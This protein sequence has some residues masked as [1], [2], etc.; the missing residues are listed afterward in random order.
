MKKIAL[1]ARNPKNWVSSKDMTWDSYLKHYDNLGNLVWTYGIFK[2]LH[3]PGN[4]LTLIDPIHPQFSADEINE[5]FDHIVFSFA[6]LL[7]S[8]KA[9]RI[10]FLAKIIS[11]LKIPVTIC[12]VGAQSGKFGDF[13]FLKPIESDVKFLFSKCLEQGVCI[14]TRGEFS[15]ECLSRLGFKRHLK[16][17]GCPSF[18][19]N[20]PEFS[21]NKKIIDHQSFRVA[22]NDTDATRTVLFQFA[23]KHYAGKFS[24]VTQGFPLPSEV[25]EIVLNLI[26]NKKLHRFGDF[27]SWNAFL[28]RFDLSISSRIHGTVMA[29]LAGVP[30][31]ILTVDARTR[32]MAD[33]L[34]IPQVGPSDLSQEK[35]PASFYEALDFH[36]M[37]SNYP[38]LVNCYS[39]FLSENQLDHFLLYSQPVVDEYF[40]QSTKQ[41]IVDDENSSIIQFTNDGFI[42]IPG[43]VYNLL[44]KIKNIFSRNGE[45]LTLQ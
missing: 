4:E 14:G 43:F 25:D 6:N 18:F 31:V 30:S 11:C 17:I 5:R 2:A 9:A 42:Q 21:I 26:R 22:F 33:L 13:D 29:L 36:K 15:S 40:C 28:K 19:I 37:N 16:T 20:G 7:D 8:N 38:S 27:L 10:Q 41:K 44:N 1:F 3:T 35:D 34:C 24:Y 23:N 32:E 39:A 12:S 45:K